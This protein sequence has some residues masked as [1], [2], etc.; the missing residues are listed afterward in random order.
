MRLKLFRAPR[1]AEAMAQVRAELGEDAVILGSRRVAGGVEVTAALDVPDPVL[2]RPA[3]VRPAV[4]AGGGG[5]APASPPCPAEAP[6]PPRPAAPGPL[7]RHNL[8]AE[9]T[10][11]LG[12]D[13]AA[14]LPRRL[15]EALAFAPLPEGR[16]RP[17]LLAGPPGAGKTLTCAKLATRAVLGGAA[18]LVVTTDSA[19]AGA[20]EQLA[21]FTRLLGLTLALADQPGTLAKALAHAA[22]GQPV[23][24]DSPGCDPFDAAEARGLLAMARA[25][26]AEVALVLPAGLD[27]AEASELAR[28]FALLGARHLVPTR[29]DQARRLGGVLAA[30]DAAGLALAEAGVGAG[31]ADGLARITPDWLAARLLGGAAREAAAA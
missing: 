25:A 24:I 2:I 30:A 28:G 14:A 29:L 3:L 8:P 11:K 5:P 18:P 23:L 22:P 4:V 17:L 1:M 16:P 10:A 13:G 27:P 6:P 21:A 7:A 19:R 31:A 26:E 9:L 20:A 15:A 12:G